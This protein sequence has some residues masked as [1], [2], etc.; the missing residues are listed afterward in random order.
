MNLALDIMDIINS[1][2][3]I[4]PAHAENLVTLDKSSVRGEICND[5]LTA[6]NVRFT[7]DDFSLTFE[8]RT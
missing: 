7:L 8:L 2:T 1:V 4:R 5:L 6:D 3:T